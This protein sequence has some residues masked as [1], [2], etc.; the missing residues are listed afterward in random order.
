[1]STYCYIIQIPAAR[2]SET[3]EWRSRKRLPW[4]IRFMQIHEAKVFLAAFHAL[5]HSLL[6][7]CGIRLS[8]CTRTQA[9]GLYKE[10]EGILSAFEISFFNVTRHSY[11]FTDF[12]FNQQH[13]NS[14]F[15]WLDIGKALFMEIGL[16]IIGTI[17][18]KGN[19]CL[20]KK[21]KEYWR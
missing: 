5:V 17:L 15:I 8:G 7:R 16:H 11:T 4:G 14:L 20:K 2:D 21:K 18:V 6:K 3:E 10:G 12:P 19:L 1:M 13:A 9:V